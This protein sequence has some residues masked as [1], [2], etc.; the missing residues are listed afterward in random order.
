MPLLGDPCRIQGVSATS[1]GSL[2]HQGGPCCFQGIPATSR[3]SLPD[4]EGL[5]SFQDVPA[6][7][8]GSLLLPGGPCCFQGF[9]A[10]SRGT[11]L[12]PKI[13]ATFI[14]FLHPGVPCHAQR[15][16][17]AAPKGSLPLTGGPCRIQSVPFMPRW[18]LHCP[19]GSCFAHKIPLET[20]GPYCAQGFL[21]MPRG[22]CFAHGGSA[23]TRGGPCTKGITVLLRRSLLHCIPKSVHQIKF[24]PIL[25]ISKVSS[26]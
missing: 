22:I 15:V 5:C 23:M 16:H 20:R 3:G 7:S 13:F 17:E 21:A 2:P 25:A 6:A 8:R 12:L 24:C 18:I 9:P 14:E 26:P 10:A 1:R 4:Q 11:L 19:G